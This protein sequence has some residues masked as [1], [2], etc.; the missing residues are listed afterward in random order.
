MARW[1]VAIAL[2]IVAASLGAEPQGTNPPAFLVLKTG[3]R[4]ATQKKAGKFIAELGKYL[5]PALRLGSLE[6]LI[7]NKPEEALALAERRHPLF[8][9]VTPGFFLEHE[10][11]LGL[12]AVAE[13]RRLGQEGESYSLLGRKG[14]PAPGAGAAVA[15]SL[16]GE[17]R[18]L[19][20]V[21]LPRMDRKFAAGHEF[22]PAKNLA[23]AV[24][25]LIEGGAGAPAAV[26]VDRATLVFFREDPQVWPKLEVLSSTGALPADLVVVFGGAS[27]GDRPARL[28][29]SL[30]KMLGDEEGRKICKS[31]QTE[32]F[33][34]VEGARLE[35]A[36]ALYR[37]Q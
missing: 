9:I 20:Q 19:E 37:A 22:E 12:V 27:A 24:Y 3:E 4:D 26:L 32:G 21:V 16:L 35:Q 33:A 10:E 2:V 13:T 25:D 29:G 28:W 8:G 34:K 1:P 31:L 15:T 23:D 6:G 7:T 36:R 18:Y 14:S 11:K 17:R 30:E 5:A